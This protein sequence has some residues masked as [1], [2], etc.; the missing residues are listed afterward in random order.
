MTTLNR[1]IKSALVRRFGGPHVSVK[2]GTGTARMWVDARVRIAK[3]FDCICIAGQ[4]W[5]RMCSEARTAAANEAR[6][7]AYAAQEKSGEKFATYY[8]DGPE[9]EPRAC[10]NLEVSLIEKNEN[11]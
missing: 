9:A 8:S 11:H 1:F 3:P 10:F 6:N 4:P 5:C 2:S 7:I